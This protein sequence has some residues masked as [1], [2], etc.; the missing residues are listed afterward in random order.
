MFG[1]RLAVLTLCLSSLRVVCRVR[2]L[3]LELAANAFEVLFRKG[4]RQSSDSATADGCRDVC[5]ATRSVV[6]V[7]LSA[8]NGLTCAL[9]SASFFRSL[10]S[11][12]S[13]P[14]S[15]KI[16][17]A[18]EKGRKLAHPPGL[19]MGGVAQRWAA[20]APWG[21][22]H[23]REAAWAATHAIITTW[24]QGY[25]LNLV[26]PTCQ[27]HLAGTLSHCRTVLGCLSR[28]GGRLDPHGWTVAIAGRAGV[29]LEEFNL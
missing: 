3:S 12:P 13:L 14:L 26:R 27:H 4:I 25:H 17:S 9:F 15:Q 22:T 7:L 5:G 29:R 11:P 28:G 23:P 1:V 6:V 10:S 20:T 18:E 2:A 8:P 19:R 21:E 16:R 24:S